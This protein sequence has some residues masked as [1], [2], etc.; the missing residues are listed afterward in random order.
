MTKR[1]NKFPALSSQTSIIDTHCHLDMDVYIEDLE[2]VLRR[3]AQHHVEHIITIGIDV[4]SSKRAITLA[5]EHDSLSATIGIHPHDVDTISSATYE[6]LG[7]M[8]DVYREHIVGYGEIGLDYVKEYSAADSQRRHFANQLALARDLRL[9][10]IIHD[11]E[12]HEDTLRILKESHAED[13]G[14]V[15]HCFSG[16][17]EFAQAVLDLGFFISI[18]GVVTFKNAVILQEVART[19][20]LASMLLETD[21]PYLSPHPLR[22][23]RNEPVHVLHTAACIA[24][25]RDISLDELAS[26]TTANARGL[27]RLPSATHG[28][29]L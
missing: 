27:F 22:G 10:V 21:G 7:E 19:I 8:A 5:Q 24:D 25:L 16:D 26:Q 20:P 28:G 1:I 6:A 3:A 29:D 2:E 18:P 13:N 11:R 14:G 12:A 17:L 15:M 9:P 4:Q 23:K